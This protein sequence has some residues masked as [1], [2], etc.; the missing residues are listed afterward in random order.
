MMVKCDLLVEMTQE[1]DVSKFA[2]GN[3][4]EQS[5]IWALI[6]QKQVLSVDNL[7]S[8]GSVSQIT[9]LPS[10]HRS[11]VI[12]GF[13]M[14]FVLLQ[15][16]LLFLVLTVA[17]AWIQSSLTPCSVMEMKPTSWNAPTLELLAPPLAI[18]TKMSVSSVIQGSVSA[19]HH[20][21]TD[22]HYNSTPLT[23]QLILR[24]WQQTP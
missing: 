21:Q 10:H 12:A 19:H 11:F 3:D 23:K 4:L 14:T 18:T 9:F 7:A 15:G 17:L 6:V 16:L 8:P 20:N 22:A 1:V 2:T 24:T 5:V 13:M